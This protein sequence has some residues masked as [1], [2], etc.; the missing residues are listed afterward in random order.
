MAA[1]AR[2][3]TTQPLRCS[4]ASRLAA[5][6][7]SAGGSTPF[8]ARPKLTTVPD[9]PIAAR[10]TPPPAPSD[11]D[12]WEDALADQ[13]VAVQDT[14]DRGKIL[15]SLRA[16]EPGDVVLRE[17]PVLTVVQASS[18]PRMADLQKW[19]DAYAALG[20]KA[21]GRVLALHCF[22]QAAE[23]DA[24]ASLL[25]RKGER[26]VGSIRQPPGVTSA[27][28]WLLLRI[29]ECNA[30]GFTNEAGAHRQLLLPRIARVNHS[31]LPNLLCGPCPEHE[32]AA[33]V[34]AIRKVVAGV[35]L[36][37]SYI[38][39]EMLTQPATVRRAP[40]RE[41][42]QFECACRQCCATDSLRAFRCRGGCSCGPEAL[43]Y[44]MAAGA[45][46]AVC[47]QCGQHWGD[48]A[49]AA[50]LAAEVRLGTLAPA[51]QQAAQDACRGLSV[52]LERRD[53]VA[54]GVATTAAS[55]A[56]DNCVAATAS[57]PQVAST[58]HLALGVARAAAKLRAM[59]GEGF[60]AS[61]RREAAMEHWSAAAAQLQEALDGEQRAVPVPRDSRAAELVSLGRLYRRLGQSAA[62]R[63]CFAEALGQMLAVHWSCNH[64][65]VQRAA[66]LEMQRGIEASLAEL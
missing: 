14:P 44:G 58:H 42:W 48:D 15:V 3:A 17:A 20:P 36:N 35:E 37:I 62:V 33:E 25:G 6:S 40:L 59:L 31:C 2:S 11:E 22:E 65:A 8:S 57:C 18:T 13:R 12:V 50:V 7:G 49:V 60:A 61:G 51:V 54:L 29:V 34:R 16:L 39:L 1:G 43:V 10:T 46:L 56:L 28:I 55:A 27:D 38:G 9:S 52:A 64:S 66:L 53:G 32:G 23:K 24:L 5:R 4:L 30:F 45:R 47:G 26:T 63:S 19:V 21:R 41:R